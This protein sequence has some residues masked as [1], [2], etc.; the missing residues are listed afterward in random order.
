MVMGRRE[1]APQ[2]LEK[3]FTGACGERGVPNWNRLVLILRRQLPF[4]AK[5]RRTLFLNQRGR[6]RIETPGN[7]LPASV[8]QVPAILS[9]TVAQF[10]VCLVPILEGRNLTVGVMSFNVGDVK[11]DS[12]IL[13]RGIRDSRFSLPGTNS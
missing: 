9:V 1:A 10:L 13:A 5:R 6:Q 4:R 2:K 7:Q 8:I 12:A 3:R 11:Q